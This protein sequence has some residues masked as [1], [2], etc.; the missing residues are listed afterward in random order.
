MPD[1]SFLAWP[2]FDATHR[3]LAAEAEAW[4]AA[5]LSHAD[6]AD[7]DAACRA[8]A[9]AMGEAD[10]FRHCMP[11]GEFDVRAL[12]LMREILARHAP[13][14]D[15][16]F[17][18][19]GLGT[20][21][22]SLFGTREQRAQ[23][24]PPVRRGTALAA[25]ALSE[26]DAGSDVAAMC[27]TARR[28]GNGWVLDGEKTWI[29]NGGIAAHFYV[30]FA[31]QVDPGEA[32]RCARHE[33]DRRIRRRCR[34]TRA[35][36][37]GTSSTRWP[38]IRSRACAFDGLLHSRPMRSAWPKPGAGLQAGDVARWTS[39][40]PTVAAAALGFARRAL[41]EGARRVRRHGANCSAAETV[42]A[43]ADAGQAGRHGD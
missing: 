28:D 30:V 14:A 29:S 5:S 20:G 2:F 4:A 3:A 21:A 15:F 1:T 7:V 19:Q 33:D 8:L 16:V 9:A 17:A 32:S 26:P 38:R 31:R 11:D 10:L 13:L 22:I 35:A 40:A 43:A 27:M 18:M 37:R 36:H 6:D 41:A 25:F 34:H 23:W 42:R 39:S 12:C 24:L